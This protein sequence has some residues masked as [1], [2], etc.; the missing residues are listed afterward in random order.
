MD[1]IGD[2]IENDEDLDNINNGLLLSPPASTPSNN[3]NNNNN[4]N[5]DLPKP[6]EDPQGFISSLKQRLEDVLK[7]AFDSRDELTL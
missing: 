1:S 3:N 6:T 7:A 5:E 2:D 4:K